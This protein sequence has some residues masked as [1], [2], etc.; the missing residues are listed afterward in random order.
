MIKDIDISENVNEICGPYYRVW[1]YLNKQL[2][3][4]DKWHL[5]AVYLPTIRT[6][7]KYQ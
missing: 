4:S 5:K 1:E 7:M 2:L 3:E 6:Q